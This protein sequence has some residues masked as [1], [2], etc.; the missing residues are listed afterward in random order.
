[1]YSYCD[2]LSVFVIVFVIVAVNNVRSDEVQF[3]VNYDVTW[4]S[5]HVS[6]IDQGRE[7]QLSMDS[8]SG[9]GFG[10]KLIYGSGFF[11]MRIKLPNKNTAGVVTAFY[12]SSNT[13]NHDEIDFEFLGNKEGKP[14]ILQTN[15]F[16]NG[17]LGNREQ[18]IR[19][20]FDP[21]QAFHTYLILWNQHQV[22]FYVDD[23]PIRVFK[24]NT[25]IGV[26][27]PTQPMQILGS[28]WD[29]S[30][31]ATD[32]GRTKIDWAFAPFTAHFQD[33]NVV[34][35]PLSSSENRENCYGSN[36]W[37]NDKKY[38]KLSRNQQEEY[39]RVRTQYLN[40]DYCDDRERFPTPPPECPYN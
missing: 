11:H 39:E 37:W 15:V 6:I 33:F 10:S 32:G 36:Y 12:L 20:W 13:G 38:W 21:T 27:Y 31:W 22:V 2:K 30:D 40:Y 7:V 14:I 26:P 9:S 34:A 29:G 16:A 18:R 17:Q 28:I 19:L 35:C 5:D 4:G 25:N 1:M 8:N 24:N 23:I 3:D